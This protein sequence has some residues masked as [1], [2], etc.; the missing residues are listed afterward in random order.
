MYNAT[1]Y[2]ECKHELPVL[3]ASPKYTPLLPPRPLGVGKEGG[4]EPPEH[5]GRLNK[6]KG[7]VSHE[8]YGLV[9]TNTAFPQIKVGHIILYN[10]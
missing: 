5:F 8:K 6:K 9:Q 4:G 3:P 2:H 1:R 7:F 10:K